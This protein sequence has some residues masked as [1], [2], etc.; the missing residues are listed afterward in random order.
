V[1]ELADGRVAHP[2]TAAGDALL[3]AIV[4]PGWTL[5]PER[6]TPHFDAGAV[7]LVTTA[8]LAA[9]A[10]GLGEP[11]ATERMRPN[12]LID[13]GAA[14][15][16]L[17]DGW[18]GRTL[19]IGEVTL[20]IVG[21]TERCVMV[22]HAQPGLPRHPRLLQAVGRVNDACAGVYADVVTPGRIRAGDPVTLL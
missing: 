18:L 21:R 20:R 6:A 14:D 16:L 7:H 4:P 3:A 5:R 8:T 10:E 12:L 17:E 15:G 13:A 19:A 9:L 22:G 1:I 11:I 2:G